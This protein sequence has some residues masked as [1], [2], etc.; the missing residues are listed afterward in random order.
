VA[1]P[2]DATR[3]REELGEALAVDD[4]PTAIRF[5]KGDVG[6]EIPALRRQDGVDLLA[7]PAPGMS[8]EVLLVAVGPFAAMSL[9]VAERLRNQ[10]IGVTVVDPRWV[11]P[12]PAALQQ[13]AARHKLVVT[14]ED[15]GVAGGVGS[16]VSAALR[17]AENDV[18]C[19]D[20][21]LPQ[22]FQAHAARKEVLAA[23]G[24]TEQNVA[25]Q[26]TGWVAALGTAD[27]ESAVS[28]QMD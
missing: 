23:V 20:V 25:R 21:G 5:P 7:I 1:A 16:A 15:N 8:D 3:L 6:D 14:L 27:A 4:G 10:G 2:R 13:L 28:E 26:I 11:L 22:A 18:P 9:A 24:L 19:R 12:V 17:R